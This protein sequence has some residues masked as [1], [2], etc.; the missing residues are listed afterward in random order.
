[1]TP[2]GTNHLP[3]QSGALE[4]CQLHEAIGCPQLVVL[5]AGVN[6][7]PLEMATVGSTRARYAVQARRPGEVGDQ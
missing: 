5:A 3:L 2:G 1:M 7:F 6:P 4:P